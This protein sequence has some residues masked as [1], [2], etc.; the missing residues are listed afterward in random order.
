V[1]TTSSRFGVL[2]AAVLTP[3]AGFLFVVP[4]GGLVAAVDFVLGFLYPAVFLVE[5]TLGCE[6]ASVTG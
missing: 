6:C 3:A 4:A 1:G 5:D 2:A